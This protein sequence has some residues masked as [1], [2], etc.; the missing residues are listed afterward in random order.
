MALL[1]GAWDNEHERRVRLLLLSKGAVL[2]HRFH[3]PLAAGMDEIRHSVSRHASGP[4]RYRN[5]RE[6][7]L[8][9]TYRAGS[10]RRNGHCLREAETRALAA[11]AL[12]LADPRACARHP[13]V[14]RARHPARRYFP[15]ASQNFR[16]SASWS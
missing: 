7:Q 9:Q 10:R 5:A 16:V 2:A 6:A 4:R 15:T 14:C 8:Q 11:R 12:R 13:D 1:A 3:S